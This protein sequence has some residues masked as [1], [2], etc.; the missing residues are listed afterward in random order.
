M[1]DLMNSKYFTKRFL[2]IFL[3]FLGI[4]LYLNTF[5]NEFL[6]DD[7][8]I[9]KNAY[10]KD[11]RYIPKCFS[12][13]LISG[14]GE[15]SNYW[16]PL[17]LL[18]FSI[19]WH[20]VGP[21]PFLFH[22]HNLF[23]HIIS[24]IL[25]FL[26]LER[27]LKKKWF[28]F[29]VSLLFLIH[30]LQTEAVTY[31]AGRGD[32]LSVFFIF[33]S[34]FLF[35]KACERPLKKWYFLSLFCFVLALLSK[36]TA[37]VT[38]FLIVLLLLSFQEKFFSPNIINSSKKERLKEV[39]FLSVNRLIPFFVVLVIFI[40][41][42]L[43]I[44]NFH[45]ILNFWPTP[46][47]Y[48][49]NISVRIFTFFRILL[50]Y[51]GLN[52]LPLNL[53]MERNVPLETSFFS[54]PVFS[55]FLV[56]LA[57]IFFAIRSFLKYL[58][59]FSSSLER[60]NVGLKTIR[61]QNCLV[62]R[63]GGGILPRTERTL[64]L[65]QSERVEKA[66]S[67]APFYFF[68]IG[69]F[70]ICLAPYSNIFIPINAIIYEH[71]MYLP[72]IGIFIC[73][74]HFFENI[75]KENGD[76]FK[77]ILILLLIFYLTFFSLKTILRN[78]EWRD[79][80]V[81]YNQ[82]LENSRSHRVY[83][84]LGNAYSDI[85]EYKKAEEMYLEAI[86]FDPSF[87]QPEAYNNLGLAFY[88]QG[89]YDKAIPYF[90]KALKVKSNFIPSIIN[91]ADAYFRKKDWEGAREY[92]LLYSKS[93]PYSFYPYFKLGEISFY[94]GNCAESLRYLE[95]AKEVVPSGDKEFQKSILFLLEEAK[96]CEQQ[97]K[98]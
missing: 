98:H 28:S 41:L 11:W 31:I 33:L 60:G 58:P 79:P 9:I 69:W 2:I 3:I 25:L 46:N 14:V 52:F 87:P 73:A 12:Q 29:L 48:T 91:L 57:M 37:M 35:I 63:L 5:F 66:T 92:F 56:F 74:V 27:L 39:I 75:L 49:E 44:L 65:E 76:T 55:G 8:D 83:N 10:I 24:A 34:L 36:E 78:R 80:I 17:L 23:L 6:W 86:N 45:N 94:E 97:I 61:R 82:I 95:A 53:H 72:L 84:N 93:T 85:G 16:R 20:I 1:L 67:R 38:P 77:K 22:F 88:R 40:S 13:N 43:T 62:P 7:D 71:W 96:K 26:I 89:Q 15:T 50:T 32:P 51:L 70:L 68:G 47:I 42:R 64:P 21:Q 59:S 81:F 19:D 54:F 90:E 30:P 4:V 18:S